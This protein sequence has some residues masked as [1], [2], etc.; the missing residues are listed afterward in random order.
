MTALLISVTRYGNTSMG[1]I[2]RGGFI[3]ITWKGDHPPW[4]VQVYRDGVL[5]VKWNLEDR[6][7]M[8]GEAP[9][10]SAS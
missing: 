1:K 5:I 10:R 4:H 6:V 9:G 2:R 3:F 8:R 7:P